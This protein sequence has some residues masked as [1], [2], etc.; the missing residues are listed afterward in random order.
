MKIEVHC[1]DGSDPNCYETVEVDLPFDGLSPNNVETHWVKEDGRQVVESFKI[2]PPNK[3]WIQ[4]NREILE[5]YLFEDNIES[6]IKN[7]V[8]EILYSDLENDI[9]E[10]CDACGSEHTRDKEGNI[11][12]V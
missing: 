12:D 10:V 8:F 4:Q 3:E 11:I 5:R 9:S 2:R 1:T 6:V 7:G